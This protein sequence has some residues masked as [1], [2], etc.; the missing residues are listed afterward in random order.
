MPIAV[1]WQCHL[2][3]TTLLNGKTCMITTRKVKSKKSS[4]LVFLAI[5]CHYTVFVFCPLSW[6][7][8][9]EQIKCNEARNEKS[10]TISRNAMKWS[11]L[12]GSKTFLWTSMS[13]NSVQINVFLQFLQS[14]HMSNVTCSSQFLSAPVFASVFLI[15]ETDL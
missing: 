6:K 12:S 3:F 4:S 11:K 7:T 10:P 15:V 8:T 1:I 5:I 2:Y 14:S 13:W 9:L